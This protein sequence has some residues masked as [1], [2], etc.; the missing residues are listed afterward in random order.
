MPGLKWVRF[1]RARVEDE[2]VKASPDTGE[3]AEQLTAREKDKEVLR[4]SVRIVL[5]NASMGRPQS[6]V[7]HDAL[8][9]FLAGVPVG[10]KWLNR[11]FV[12]V[13]EHLGAQALKQTSALLL[14]EPL[15]ALGIPSDI[16]LWLDQNTIGKIFHAVRSTVLILGVTVS[17]P[18]ARGSSAVFLDA[19]AEGVDGRNQSSW[20][21][22]TTTLSKEPWCMSSNILR[23][24]LAVAVGDGHFAEGEESRH[25]P[26][27]SLYRQV[28]FPEF[29]GALFIA[30]IRLEQER[31]QTMKWPRNS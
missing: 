11:N 20:G 27:K 2:H 9:L 1:Y 23:A 4:R 25:T 22:I 29:L 7:R 31:L 18:D 30:W 6:H 17:V 19:P 14:S 28:V 26:V 5:G 12:D 15:P 16:E 10:H 8:Q 3:R 13:A 24:R 21:L